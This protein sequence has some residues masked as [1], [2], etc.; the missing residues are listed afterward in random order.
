MVRSRFIADVLF[1][2]ATAAGKAAD[3][4]V[5]STRKFD[6][7]T[8]YRKYDS[9]SFFEN[10]KM[11]TTSLKTSGL[12]DTFTN[13]KNVDVSS[14]LPKASNTIVADL[15]QKAKKVDVADSTLTRVGKISD[16]LLSVGMDI[17]HKVDIDESIVKKFDFRKKVLGVD[18]VKV[19]F[20]SP[21]D[22]FVNKKLMDKTDE[23][24][25]TVAKKAKDGPIMKNLKTLKKW[26]GTM[27]MVIISSYFMALH[28]RGEA[29]WSSS[30]E[31]E[32]ILKDPF[33]V[34]DL[35]EMDIVDASSFVEDTK[36]NLIRRDAIAT[37]MFACILVIFFVVGSK[38]RNPKNFLE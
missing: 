25:D 8:F 6:P 28:V 9:S 11:P 32:E 10:L 18:E 12:L 19:A 37:A 17:T 13:L 30:G 4:I 33:P 24:V 23:V 38:R 16:D 31:F 3:D 20:K 14:L 35:L 21:P 7:S 27:N 1:E 26:E 29:P 2:G 36:T 5:A 22:S 15:A 34:P